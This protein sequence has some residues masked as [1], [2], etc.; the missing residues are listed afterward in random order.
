MARWPTLVLS[1]MFLRACLPAGHERFVDE[2]LVSIRDDTSFFRQYVRREEDI[3]L[4][5]EHVK[6]FL[7]NGAF[8]IDGE[9][10]WGNER[11]YAVQCGA[12][13]RCVVF[14]HLGKD[15]QIATANVLMKDVRTG[16]S[17]DFVGTLN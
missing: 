16:R 4:L 9:E 10:K 8:Q 7:W 3:R 5:Q 1:M 12:H 6:P 11:E 17:P 14:V 15:G 2:F 13:I